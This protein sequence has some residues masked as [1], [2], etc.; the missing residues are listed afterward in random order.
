MDAIPESLISTKYIEPMVWVIVLWLLSEVWASLKKMLAKHDSETEKNTTA[1]IKLDKS[2]ALLQAQIE[3][4]SEYMSPVPR[5]KKEK[6]RKL[7]Q[8]PIE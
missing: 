2:I 7:D 3:T 8:H 6:L 5:H 4:L 1:I